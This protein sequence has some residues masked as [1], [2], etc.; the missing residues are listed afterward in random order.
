MSYSCIYG[1]F[2]QGKP[3]GRFLTTTVGIITSV[4][5]RRGAGGRSVPL[6]WCSPDITDPFRSA[7]RPDTAKSYV[8]FARAKRPSIMETAEKI[9]QE[10]PHPNQQTSWE[11][12]VTLAVIYAIVASSERR[13][14]QLRDQDRKNRSDFLNRLLIWETKNITPVRH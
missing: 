14:Q 9:L 3:L 4:A 10:Q 13:M 1:A 8:R 11:T 12:Q 7:Q 6:T 5:V 2:A